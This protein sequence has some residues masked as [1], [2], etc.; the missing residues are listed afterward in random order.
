MLKNHGACDTGVLARICA[1]MFQGHV[2]GG[3]AVCLRMC[4]CAGIYS[5]QLNLPL[6]LWASTVNLRTAM[7]NKHRLLIMTNKNSC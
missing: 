5:F 7:N 2:V 4:L 6:P 1:K 3:T